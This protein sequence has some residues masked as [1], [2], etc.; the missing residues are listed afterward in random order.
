M[1][2]TIICGDAIAEVSK[3]PNLSVQ[4]CITSPPYWGLRDYGV[5]GQ[6]GH[7]ETPEV[8]VERLVELFAAI[9]EKLT[10]SGTVWLNLGDSYFGSRKGSGGTYE[11]SQ[12]QN[13][14]KGANFGVNR[15]AIRIPHHNTLKPKDLVGIPWRVALALQADGWYLRNDIIW[16][17]PN[18][19]PS[20]VRDRFT[21]AHEYVFLLTKSPKYLFNQQFEPYSPS[22]DAR[23]RQRLRAGR[24][25]EQKAPYKANLPY[26]SVKA[27]GDNKDRLVVGGFEERGRNARTVWTIPTKPYKG[28]HFATFPENLVAPCILAGSNQGDSVLD[29]FAGSGT[30]GVVAKQLERNSILIELNPEYCKLI[31]QRVG[32]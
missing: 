32:D 7:E 1:T 13:T 17:K 23:Y 21:M 12:K 15:Q 31:A 28:A 19:M 18:V 27:R 11:L 25:Y 29:P 14:N 6:I 9:G 2:T 24:V 3:I 20:S 10:D 8:Y 30:V 22:S 16:H 26:H 5:N 4:C